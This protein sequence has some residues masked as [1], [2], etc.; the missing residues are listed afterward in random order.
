M[1]WRRQIIR[2]TIIRSH[3]KTQEFLPTYRD[4]ILSQSMR[5]YYLIWLAV[6]KLL[7]HL[8][9]SYVDYL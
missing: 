8:I 3:F 7:P 4:E 9:I 1:N 6:V 2:I 5:F